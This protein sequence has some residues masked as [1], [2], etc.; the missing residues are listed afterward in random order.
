MI[1]PKDLV[2]PNNP[3]IEIYEK[4]F[5]CG[6][7]PTI[8]EFDNEEVIEIFL[9]DVRKE[10]GYPVDRSMVAAIPDWDH[11]NNPKQKTRTRRVKKVEKILFE[12]PAE[13][14]EVG[15]EQQGD[16]DGNEEVAEEI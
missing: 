12:E 4:Y 14:I 16:N 6:G 1:K 13:T 3:L 2:Y 11:I 7:F 10:T 5:W 9:E 8:S 15:N